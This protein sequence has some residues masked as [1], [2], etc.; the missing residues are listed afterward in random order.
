[1]LTYLTSISVLIDW[2]LLLLEENRDGFI[3]CELLCNFHISREFGT[4]LEV[5]DWE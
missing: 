1:M 3:L 5:E 2:G 4:G